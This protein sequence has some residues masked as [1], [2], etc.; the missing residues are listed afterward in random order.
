MPRKPRHYVAGI[1]AH[2]IHRGNNR[3]PCFFAEDDYSLY[4]EWLGEAATRYGC[5]IHAYVLMT[6]HVHM[7][8]TPMTDTA[9]SR[10]IQS[11]GRR[12]VRYINAVY[13]RSGT[14]WEGR[15]KGSL[16]QS[17][18]Y[19]LACSRYIELNP[20]RARMVSDP[21]EYPWSSYRHNAQGEANR[22]L[23]PHQ[24]YQGLGS[25]REKRMNAYRGLFIQEP[26]AE[27]VNELRKAAGVGVPAGNQCFRKE[28]EC[29][30]GRSVQP[31]RRGRPRK[32]TGK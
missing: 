18:R 6:N 26:D 1:P 21:A 9:I 25:S 22:L 29:M 7:L 31:G 20:V 15:H 12:Y 13:Q 3:Q 27:L 30:L 23:S 2:V 16:V 4:L 5:E 32:I 17:G 28:I 8:M 11:V 10:L 24:D 19:F 14:L